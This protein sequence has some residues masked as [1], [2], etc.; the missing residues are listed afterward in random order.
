MVE[1]QSAATARFTRHEAG[2]FEGVQ[3]GRVDDPGHLRGGLNDAGTEVEHTLGRS[4]KQ[5]GIERGPAGRSDLWPE[6]A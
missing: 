2:L 5:P 3:A 1:I 6:L 4:L